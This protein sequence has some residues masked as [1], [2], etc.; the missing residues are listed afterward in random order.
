MEDSYSLSSIFQPLFPLMVVFFLQSAMS[1][2]HNVVTRDSLSR[3][4][5]R[6]QYIEGREWV[7]KYATR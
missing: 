6:Q 2:G 4:Q 7:M 1:H 5:S 3:Q